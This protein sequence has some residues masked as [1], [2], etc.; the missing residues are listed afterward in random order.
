M[1]DFGFQI[2]DIRRRRRKAAGTRHCEA[3]FAQRKATKQSLTRVSNW[4]PSL[5]DDWSLVAVSNF[6]CPRF[7]FSSTVTCTGPSG[8]FCG[9]PSGAQNE[10]ASLNPWAEAHGK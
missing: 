2:S 10:S 5:R 3:H 8:A 7:A 9:A 1:S 4:H 6:L